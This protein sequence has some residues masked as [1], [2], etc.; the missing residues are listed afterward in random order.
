MSQLKVTVNSIKV[1]ADYNCFNY[2]LLNHLNNQS[3][4][5]HFRD[6][7]DVLKE[8][9]S[10]EKMEIN[11]R[12]KTRLNSSYVSQTYLRRKE[13]AL[14]IYVDTSPNKTDENCAD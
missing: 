5:F 11:Q 10:E 7:R 9:N 8:I 2:F 12:E 14:K 6:S 13:R 3:I 1:G 4:F